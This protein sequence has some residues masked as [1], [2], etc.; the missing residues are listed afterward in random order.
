MP[1][2]Y[3]TA[4]GT[5]S[6]FGNRNGSS[7]ASPTL[8]PGV[9]N[10]G[11]TGLVGGPMTTNAAGTTVAAAT[12]AQKTGAASRLDSSFALIFGAVAAI[13]YLN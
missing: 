3:P 8:T 5:G 2:A 1:Y 10:N 6:G 9:N 4:G 11:P 7:Y 13:A 12:A